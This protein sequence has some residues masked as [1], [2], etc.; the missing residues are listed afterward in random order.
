[1]KLVRPTLVDD[2]VLTSSSVAE[3]EPVHSLAT[4]YAKGFQVRGTGALRHTVFESLQAGNTGHALD[5]VG[6]PWWIR[7]GPTNRFAMF[8]SVLG[9][10]T[11]AT[12]TID[13]VLG[14]LGR[15]DSLALFNLAAASARV[16]MTSAAD[17]VVYDRTFA[18]ASTGGIVDWFDWLFEPVARLDRLVIDTLP[19]YADATLEVILSDPGQPVACG[20]LVVGFSKHLG[21][22]RWEPQLGF[23][24][25][26]VKARNSFGDASIVERP[27]YDTGAFTLNVDADQVDE[28]AALCKSL[29]ATP[30]LIIG[31]PGYA[32]TAIFGF[33]TQFQT[34]ITYPSFSVCTLD[35][36]GLT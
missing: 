18:L 8:D 26:S 9:T 30:V 25:T 4:T 20:E 14:N 1:M 33:I 15:I 36:E 29:R 32:I 3:S 27:F 7:V 16:I 24:D 2:G 13:V 11:T 22:T 28:V 12:G 10:Q 5:E 21:D 34:G 19:P 6:S 23:V 35:F 17:G 31:D